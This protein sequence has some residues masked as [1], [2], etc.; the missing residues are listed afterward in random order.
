M[1]F[2]IDFVHKRSIAIH[3]RNYWL[4]WIT[5]GT[6]PSL[7]I[8][9]NCKQSFKLQKMVPFQV[10]H[11][12]VW[13]F[14]LSF[15]FK[16][17]FI[18]VLLIHSVVLVSGIQQSELVIHISTLFFLILFLCRSLSLCRWWNSLEGRQTYIC[19]CWPPSVRAGALIKGGSLS[20]S[21][22]ERLPLP[23]S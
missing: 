13:L 6:N 9:R 14:V 23:F 3:M 22:L 2:C 18:G 1:L 20:K 17:N 5:K 19:E 21:I 15:S 10:P 4:G 16:K 11:L 7:C 8:L 12:F